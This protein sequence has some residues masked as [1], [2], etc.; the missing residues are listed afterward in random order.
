MSLPSPRERAITIFKQQFGRPPRWLARAP[1]RVNLI[2]EHTDYNDGF[3]L[4]MA[5]EQ[6]IWVAFTPR[7]DRQVCL[8]AADLDNQ[9]SQFSLDSLLPGGDGTAV[10]TAR[11]SNYARGIAWALQGRG[12][13]LT[14]FDGAISG[15]V[16][17][18]AGLSSSAALDV[19]MALAYQTASGL[20]ISRPDL[21]RLCQYSENEFVGVRCGIMDQFISLLGEAGHALLIDC[22]DLSY[23]PAP[24]PPGVRVV[25]CN[26]LV[27]RGLVDSAYNTRRAECEAGVAAFQAWKPGVKALR[28]VTEADIEQFAAQ[29]PPNVRERCRHVVSE[30]RR[31]M[32]MV[33][34]M[35]QGDLAWCGRLMA[36]SHD[37][38]RDDYE[39]SCLELDALVIAARGAPGY[40]GA[41]LT[42]AGFGGCTVN[43]VQA[44]RVA[45]FCAAVAAGYQSVTGRQT[46]IY[47]CDPAAGASVE[48]MSE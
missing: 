42:G 11:W 37:S 34:A 33:A 5:I 21:A 6:A 44:E 31:V 45:D 7:D 19:A 46:E 38:L 18:D 13:N 10:T 16:P 17:I 48:E 47:V 35:Q 36:E 23:R 9:V 4:P 3:V 43:L 28:D 15:N 29:L 12:M 8:V 26:S 40:V 24:L 41:R 25:V 32:E 30:N 2:G 20:N 22:R 1:G 14:G 39:V 27:K